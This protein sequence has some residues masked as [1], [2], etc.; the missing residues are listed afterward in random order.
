MGTPT[1]DATPAPKTRLPRGAICAAARSVSQSGGATSRDSPSSAVSR[2][3]GTTSDMRLGS[4][5]SC[6]VLRVVIWP[7]IHSMVVVTSPIGV[8]APPA[9][10]AMTTTAPKNLRSSSSGTSLRSR[11]TMTIVLVRLSRMADMKK[12]MPPM[13]H[14]SVV[15]SL[16]LML[17]VTILKPWCASTVSTIVIAPMRKKTIWDTSARDSLSE[18]S[19]SC[20]PFATARTVHMPTAVSSATPDLLNANVSSKMIPAYPSRN[21]TPS[22]TASWSATQL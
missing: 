3:S 12:V 20:P 7:L 16:V 1:R 6:I 21:T 9:F 19:T 10:A 2:P 8:Q 14:S 17:S 11:D 5:R 22:A 18:P 4:R 13:S 15:R